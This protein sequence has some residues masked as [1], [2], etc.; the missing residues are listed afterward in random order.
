[1][2]ILLFNRYQ[3]KYDD[4]NETM[5]NMVDNTITNI[6]SPIQAYYNTESDSSDF[7]DT[8]GYEDNLPTDD[9][10]I[11][12]IMLCM[13]QHDFSTKKKGISQSF[14]YHPCPKRQG[15]FETGITEYK[16]YINSRFSNF[17][18]LPIMDPYFFR[19]FI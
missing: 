10:L 3:K 12:M 17:R 2:F 4:N 11:Y 8:D 13:L 7:S 5:K 14:C 15:I 19:N 16:S 18:A 1:M 6:T 9:D